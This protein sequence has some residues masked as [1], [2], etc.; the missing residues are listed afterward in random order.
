[1]KMTVKF[2]EKDIA[3]AI[4]SHLKEGLVASSEIMETIVFY[5]RGNGNGVGAR[6][7]FRVKGPENAVRQ[8]D[9]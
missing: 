2:D 4:Q 9:Q 7:T 3:L 6:V 8:G 5:D 1:M